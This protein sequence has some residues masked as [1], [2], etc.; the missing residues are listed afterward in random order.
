VFEPSSK[1]DFVVHDRQERIYTT[2][3]LDEVVHDCIIAN[4]ATFVLHGK[5]LLKDLELGP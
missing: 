1:G 5:S 2:L 4:F 3:L